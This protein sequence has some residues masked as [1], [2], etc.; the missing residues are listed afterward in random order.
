MPGHEVDDDFRVH[1]GLEDR[2]LG[3]QAAADLP[4]VG[5]GAVVGDGDGLAAVLH[6]EGLG[7][8]DVGGAGGGVAHVADGQMPRQRLQPRLVEDLGHQ[9]HAPVLTDALAVAGDDAAGL[10]APVLQG[11]EPEEGQP[12]RLRMAVNAEDAA[13]FPG[14]VVLEDDIVC[15]LPFAVCR[16]HVKPLP[17]RL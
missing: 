1:G 15:R 17:D 9:P 10:L 16:F 13:V 14:L 12:R 6:H 8:D 2:A 11:V 4:G 7:V 5:Q 3:F